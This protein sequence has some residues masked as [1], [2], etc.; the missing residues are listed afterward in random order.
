MTPDEVT[1]VARARWAAHKELKDIL[2]RDGVPY[3][4]QAG[5]P[6]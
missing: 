2:A 5:N 1:I 6:R 4:H 3:T